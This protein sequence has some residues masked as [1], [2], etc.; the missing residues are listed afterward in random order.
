MPAGVVIFP[1]AQRG[2]SFSSAAQHVL[3]VKTGL[4]VH[5]LSGEQN[6]PLCVPLTSFRVTNFISCMYF[7]VF[8]GMIITYSYI[9]PYLLRSQEIVLLS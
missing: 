1:I 2:K 8:P 7:L 5:P 3:C 9:T 4:G 6:E